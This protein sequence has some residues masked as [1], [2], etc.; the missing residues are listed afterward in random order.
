MCYCANAAGKNKGNGHQNHYARAM[1][2]CQCVIDM[3]RGAETALWESIFHLLPQKV[4]C[5]P[6][7]F[8]VLHEHFQKLNFQKKVRKR[9]LYFLKQ[10]FSWIF[11]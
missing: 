1:Q 6:R 9:S 2:E 11:T 3:S 8:I 10:L 4:I 5:E 7:L